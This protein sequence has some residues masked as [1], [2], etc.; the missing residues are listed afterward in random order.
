M[1]AGAGFVVG[2]LSN[3]QNL[4]NLNELFYRKLNSFWLVTSFKQM[5]KSK[6]SKQSVNFN[7][8]YAHFL[9]KGKEVRTS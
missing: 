2:K 7:T 4:R 6:S 1:E 9:R 3:R 8:F 5:I